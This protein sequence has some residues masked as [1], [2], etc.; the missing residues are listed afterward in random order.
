MGRQQ[1]ASQIVPDFKIRIAFRQRMFL[2]K[3]FFSLI[4]LFDYK[5][6]TLF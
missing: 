4:N 5:P 3:E 1:Y 6:L 2:N